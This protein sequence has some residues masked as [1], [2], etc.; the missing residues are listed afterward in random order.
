ML[1]QMGGI[2]KRSGPASIIA[3]QGIQFFLEFRVRASLPVCLFQFFERAHERFWGIASAIGSEVPA[4][5]GFRLDGGAAMRIILRIQ[6]RGHWFTYAV[7]EN[8][9]GKKLVKISRE[10][11]KLNR[12]NLPAA[13]R[14][15]RASK[16]RRGARCT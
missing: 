5:I 3:Q 4:G 7:R 13:P 11:R 2:V 1:R 15:A 6:S 14:A 16:L 9:T 8:G 10:D 12:T